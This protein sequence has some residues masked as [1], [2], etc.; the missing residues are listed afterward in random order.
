MYRIKLLE[1]VLS[2][3]K[4]IIQFNQ[5]NFGKLFNYFLIYRCDS[6]ELKIF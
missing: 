6:I 4:N 1:K 3:V 5:N 2:I